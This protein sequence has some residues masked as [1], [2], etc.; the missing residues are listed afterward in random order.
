[1]RFASTPPVDGTLARY[2]VLPED[3]CYMLPKSVSTEEGA[4]LEP[5]SVAVHAVKQAK[6]KYGD[7]VVVFGAGPVGLLCCAVA[8]AFGARKIIAVDVQPN[9]LKFAIEYAATAHYQSRPITAQE[10][11][12]SIIL[13]NDLALGADVAIEA[14]GVE[15]CIETAIYC[16]R[17]GGSYVQAGMGR[18]KCSFP[19][20]EVCTKELAVSGSFR[21]GPGDYETALHMISS[22]RI[23]VKPLISGKV[24]FDDVEQAFEDVRAGR[25]LKILVKGP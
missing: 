12:T 8:K 23:D 14:S 17:K 11:A 4:L 2:Y 19:I 21:Y 5:L 15:S 9:R 13:Q 22:G 20:M 16:L 7:S 1:M 25:A 24:E 6:V 10:N 3:L 18:D